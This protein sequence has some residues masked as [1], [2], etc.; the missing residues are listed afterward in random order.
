MATSEIPRY[1]HSHSAFNSAIKAMNYVGLAL[2]GIGL[3]WLWNTN[4]YD[5]V[6]LT[7]AT[8]FIYIGCVLI[9]LGVIGMFLRQTARVIVEG[10]GGR[11]QTLDADRSQRPPYNP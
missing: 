6:G 8:G 10:L 9:S 1:N 4:S 7:W 11:L 3:F 5:D 2:L